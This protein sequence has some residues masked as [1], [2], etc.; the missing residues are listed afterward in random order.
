MFFRQTY[1][2]VHIE[3]NDVL[4]RNDAFLFRSIKPLYIPKG[5]E[6]VGHP[7]TN[8]FSA[9]GLAAFDFSS[10]IVCRPLRYG[11]IVRLND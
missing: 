2:F 10:N 6:P 3:S 1:I 5:E 9:V 7:K 4:E 11:L 8:G